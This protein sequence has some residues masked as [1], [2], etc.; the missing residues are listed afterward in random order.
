MTTG[1]FLVTVSPKE[2]LDGMRSGNPGEGGYLL[3][4]LVWEDGELVVRRGPKLDRR[5]RRE[6]Q[7]RERKARGRDVWFLPY[8]S[9]DFVGLGVPVKEKGDAG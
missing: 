5:E 1:S 8:W 2:F 7:R 3:L 4:V 6:F 9:E